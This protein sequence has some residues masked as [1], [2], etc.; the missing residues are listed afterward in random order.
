MPPVMSPDR[1]AAQAAFIAK[2]L[3][4]CKQFDK[5]RLT[6]VDPNAVLVESLMDSLRNMVLSFFKGGMYA[7]K[8]CEHCGTTESPQFERAHTAGISRGDVALLALRRIRP[9]ETQPVAQ[10]HF[11]RAFIEEHSTVPL[12]VLCKACHRAY[13]SPTPNTV[14]GK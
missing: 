9:D 11:L 14:D 12:W 10:A 8:V 13:D 2:K 1:L 4:A 5:Y 3:Q 6:L 7:K